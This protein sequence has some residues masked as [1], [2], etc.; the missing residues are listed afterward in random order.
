MALR[1][2]APASA[3]LPAAQA[4]LR[5]PSLYLNRE[6]SWLEFNARVLS[7][8]E[9]EAV[10]LLERLKFH[11]IVASNLDEFFMVRVAG[12]RQQLSGDVG[13][14]PADGMTVS[15]QLAAI[16]RRVHALV[17]RQ[18]ASLWGDLMPKL[19]AH[20]TRLYRPEE[21]PPEQLALLDRQFEEEVFP[22]LTPI[23]IDPG[24][25]FPHVRNRSLNLGVMFTREGAQE[26][27]FGVVQVPMMI[28]RLLE[29]T[30]IP[31]ARHAFV[32]LEELIA[33]HVST[34]FPAVKVKGVYAFRVTRNFD[35]TIDEE[36][37]QDLLQTIQQELRKR[38]RGGAVRLEIAGDP[39]ASSLA[40][41]VRSLKLDLDRDVYR[42][43]RMLNVADLFHIVGREDRRELRDEPFTPV[44][45]PPLRDADDIFAMIREGDILLH[46]PY[47]SFESV[48][49]LVTRAADD[50]D[51]LAIKQTLYRAGGDSPIVKALARAA[52]AGKQVTALVELKARFDEESNIVWARTLEQS[53]VHV[54]YGLM[55]LKTHAKC[56]LIVRREQ[57]GLRRYVHLS[58]GNYNTTTAR[59]YTDVSI[60]TCRPEIGEDAS[61]LFNLLTGYAAPPRWNTF[62]VAP[63]GLHEAVLGLIAREAEH[64]RAGRPASIVAKMNAL[65]DEDVIE[66]LYRASQSG[67]HI[68]LLVRGIC[69]LR[70]GVAGV[71]ENIEV[72][73]L[74]DR[75]LEHGRLFQFSNGGEPEMYIASA[76]WMPRNFHRRVEVMVP[77]LAPE[78]RARLAEIVRIELSD[79]AKAWTLTP[80]GGYVRVEAPTTEPPARAQ[81][82]FIEMTRGKVKVADVTTRPSGRFHMTS[83]AQRSPLEG[84]VPKTTR[85]RARD[86]R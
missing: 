37:A 18:E 78:L 61:S 14:M 70:P 53:G 9:N 67:V 59:L 7:E 36:E 66:A 35:I 58:T 63:L 49:E 30:G 75:Y 86:P 34:I 38:E 24:H 32:R 28:P 62:I 80:D 26:A 40:K 15:E 21:L 85:R 76:D 39:T 84:R 19:A 81:A 16:A 51:V 54:V 74:I 1:D 55:G 50:P 48:V 69:C 82:R 10:P 77:V 11:A 31:D 2:L 13:E 25:P 8:A 33:R 20:G 12:L 71:S 29:V 57:G 79:R 60:L 56:L 52:E 22:I 3:R 43:E 83:A 65:V 6:L 64:A 68:T 17:A 4:D 72:R 23:V 44:V 45:V 46:H 41:L 47:E 5:D 42:V 73:T 27:G